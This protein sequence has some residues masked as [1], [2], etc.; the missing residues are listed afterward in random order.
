[1]DITKIDSGVL[2]DMGGCVR[3]AADAVSRE[4]AGLYSGVY[5]GGGWG[6]EWGE[7]GAGWR[8]AG[9]GSRSG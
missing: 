5:D 1:M 9:R 7:E 3:K 4:G 6:G 2:C 8:R